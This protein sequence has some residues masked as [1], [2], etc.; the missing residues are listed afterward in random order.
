L[1]LILSFI[2][3]VFLAAVFQLSEVLHQAVFPYTVLFQTV[4]I[5]AVAPLL[6]I[7]FGFGFYTILASAFIVS[8]FP[9]LAG[10]MHGLSQ[11]SKEHLDL[12]K[13]Y[14]ASKLKV[15]FLLRMPSAKGAIFNGLKVASGL[16]IVGAIVGEFIAGGGLGG[17]I[18]TARTQQRVDQVFAAVI[19][20]SVVGLIFILVV[21]KIS[22][23]IAD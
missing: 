15:L 14:K 1:G 5:I 20:S 19:L 18:D 3:G 21:N 22:A 23:R 16:S 12:F 17:L 8:L 7:W 6:V 9:I 4:P 2:V 11:V 10:S 13:L